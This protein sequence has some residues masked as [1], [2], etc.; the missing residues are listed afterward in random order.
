LL[1]LQ[2][3]HHNPGGYTSTEMQWQGMT[4]GQDSAGDR[5]TTTRWRDT[6]VTTVTPPPER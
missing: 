3:L 6:T 1:G 5:W 4:L 2:R